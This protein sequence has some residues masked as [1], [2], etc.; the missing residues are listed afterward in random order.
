MGLYLIYD[1][2]TKLIAMEHPTLGPIQLFGQT[3]WIGWLMIAA[4]AYSIVPPV[5]LGRLKQPV[6][7]R[8]RTRCCTPTR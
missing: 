5:V 8:L 2:G 3:I 7:K 1:S 4:L 6:A